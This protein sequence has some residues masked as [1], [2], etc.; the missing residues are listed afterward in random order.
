MKIM[1]VQHARAMGGSVRS[2][3]ILVRDA[4]AAGHECFIL[5]ANHEIADHYSRL[6]AKAVCSF[7]YPMDH[8]SSHWYRLSFRGVLTGIRAFVF[9]VFSAFFFSIMTMRIRPDIVHLNSATLFYLSPVASLMRIK[10]IIHIRENVVSGYF[11]VRRF[12]IR[13]ILNVFCNA[14]VYISEVERDLLK[15]GSRK[16]FVI[17]NYVHLDFEKIS[18]RAGAQ[19]A[20]IVLSLGGISK[21]K[22]TITLLR[23]AC[24]LGSSWR[25]RIVGTADPTS[26]SANSKTDEY[27]SSVVQYYRANTLFEKL[28]FIG[29][30][31]DVRQEILSAKV[32]V[33]WGT[34]PH[35]PRPVFEAF[36]LNCP[37]IILDSAAL[38]PEISLNCYRVVSRD[39]PDLLVAALLDLAGEDKDKLENLV[40]GAQK[41]AQ[42]K[43]VNNFLKIDRLYSEIGNG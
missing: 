39:E 29:P 30:I 23:A 6:G 25:F 12:A 38:T 11:G 22:G 18:R 37:V 27:T 19:A 26:Q 24:A 1:Y 40:L 10:N 43:F 41:F 4:L 14:V 8:N 16:S 42:E 35:F 28:K 5:C 20:S 32:L 36:L 31:D 13:I 3:S 33:F 2:L 9:S 15:T 7:L 21:I 17:Y 34:V